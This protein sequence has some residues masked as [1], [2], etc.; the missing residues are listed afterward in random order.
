MRALDL[1][2][3]ILELDTCECTDALEFLL[4]ENVFGGLVGRNA[5]FYP[6]ILV[7]YVEYAGRGLVT[8][9]HRR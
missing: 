4:I 5:A 7:R 9:I 3:R 8:M 6:G 2:P 1:Y